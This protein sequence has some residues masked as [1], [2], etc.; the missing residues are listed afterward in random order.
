MADQLPSWTDGQAKAQVL[1]FVRSA[2]EPWASF[3][4]APKA[5]ATAKERG[6]AVVSM[7]HDFKVVFD[8]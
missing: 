4:P 7:Q 8:L 5:L 3:A 2:T 1:E 6:W